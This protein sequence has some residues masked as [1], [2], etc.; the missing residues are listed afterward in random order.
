[1]ATCFFKLSNTKERQKSSNNRLYAENER[2][3]SQDTIGAYLNAAISVGASASI[4]SLDS[5][6]GFPYEMLGI[7]V[8]VTS[9]T[10]FL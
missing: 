5:F 1:M 6:V 3:T 7:F 8:K 9:L 10:F 2:S 4:C